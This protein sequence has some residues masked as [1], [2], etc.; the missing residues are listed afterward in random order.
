MKRLLFAICILLS[1]WRPAQSVPPAPAVST[2]PTNDYPVFIAKLP[3]PND[4]N[5]FANGGWDG[6]W[7]VGYNTCWIKKLPS[8]RRGEYARAYI[9]TKVGRMKLSANAKSVW[10]KRPV[11][12]T[13][14]M[15][16]SSTTAWT[17]DHS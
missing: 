16:L 4:Y 15:A 9:G 10:D 12:G 17:R 7:Y 6:N 3:N 2:A 5:L 13:I 8:I 1:A 11:P 14:Y